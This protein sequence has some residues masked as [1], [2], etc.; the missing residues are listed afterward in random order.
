MGHRKEGEGRGEMEKV[1][2]AK[3]SGDGTGVFLGVAG[4]EVVDMDGDVLA[5]GFVSCRYLPPCVSIYT[6]LLLL[7]CDFCSCTG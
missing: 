5:G 3:R 1:S 6:S 4:F 7:G 2:S